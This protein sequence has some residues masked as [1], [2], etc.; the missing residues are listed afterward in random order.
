MLRK[1]A[2]KNS[3]EASVKFYKNLIL[4]YGSAITHKFAIK[5][6]NSEYA[7]EMLKYY[8]GFS[9]MGGSESEV[10]ATKYAINCY[11]KVRRNIRRHDKRLE[12]GIILAFLIEGFDFSFSVE[13]SALFC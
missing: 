1:L 10:E 7:M 11:N 4:Q 9:Y 3:V 12:T 2:I 5:C 6:S 8:D 13:R